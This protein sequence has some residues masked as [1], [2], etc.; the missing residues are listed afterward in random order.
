MDIL[1]LL[2]T[3]YC[4]TTTVFDDDAL[5]S[6]ALATTSLFLSIYA[7]TCDWK[8][9]LQKLI[10]SQ[11]YIESMSNEQLVELNEKINIKE[12]ELEL[13]EEQPRVYVKK[14]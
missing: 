11:E 14:G 8:A 12:A 5:D 7:S 13:S 6:E 2:T 4:V 1:D 10:A 3:A 9:D